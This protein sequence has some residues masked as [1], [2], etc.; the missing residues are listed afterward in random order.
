MQVAHVMYVNMFKI[1]S[2]LFING[3]CGQFRHKLGLFILDTRSR[4][5]SEL[6]TFFFTE[7]AFI[8]IS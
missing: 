1:Y 6:Y 8:L 5:K 4:W 7:I 3:I 2:S